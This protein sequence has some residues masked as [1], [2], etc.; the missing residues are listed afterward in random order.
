MDHLIKLL[1]QQ[2]VAVAAIAATTTTTDNKCTLHCILNLCKDENNFT[3]TMSTTIAACWSAKATKQQQFAV[4]SL[5][6]M[7]MRLPWLKR[8]LRVGDFRLR[9]RRVLSC[10]N[11]LDFIVVT[12]VC[13]VGSLHLFGEHS[14]W[15]VKRALA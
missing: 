3:A 5:L 14:I 7:G 12:V 10:R 9:L 13:N 1:P 15:A 8:R 6:G 4:L 2:S 11:V